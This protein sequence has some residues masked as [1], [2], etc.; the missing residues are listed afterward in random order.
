MV[1]G[2]GFRFPEHLTL[3]PKTLKGI[4]GFSGLGDEGDKVLG[5]GRLSGFGVED[6]GDCRGFRLQG[7]RVFRVQG[8]GFLRT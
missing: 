3:N 7:S 2:L 8:S 1:E 6:L 5:L 4:G